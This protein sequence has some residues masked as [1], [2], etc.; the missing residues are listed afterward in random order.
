MIKKTSGVFIQS[1]T[2]QTIIHS[3]RTGNNIFLNETASAI[4][5][6]VGDGIYIEDLIVGIASEYNVAPEDIKNDI[7]K[8]VELLLSEGILIDEL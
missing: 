4:Y 1:F 8:T 5:H 2:S 6:A 7:Y 3:P